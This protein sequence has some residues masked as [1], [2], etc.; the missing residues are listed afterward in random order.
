MSEHGSRLVPLGSLVGMLILGTSLVAWS[1]PPASDPGSGRA[2]AAECVF[3][4]TARNRGTADIWIMFYE[5][6]VRRDYPI[7]PEKWQQLKIQNHRVAPGVSIKRSYTAPGRCDIRRDWRWK[8][9][10]GTNI[11]IAA[12]WTE[13]APGSGKSVDHSLG[14]INRFF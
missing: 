6:E 3:N 8:L 14:D 7:L 9:K 11:Y 12:D 10:R 1:P 4:I 13:S 2:D 5:S